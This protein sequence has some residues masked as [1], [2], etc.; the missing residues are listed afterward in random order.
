MLNMQTKTINRILSKKVSDWLLSIDDSYL[1]VQ[2]K[3]KVVV[4]G[5]CI[6]SMLQNQTPNDYDLYI[7][8]PLLCQKLTQYYVNKMKTTKEVLV[9]MRKEG[10]TYEGGVGEEDVSRVSPKGLYVY[11]YIRDSGYVSESGITD[12]NDDI[13]N[14]YEEGEKTPAERSNE[15][16]EKGEEYRP[17]FITSNAVTLSDKFQIITRFSG[18]PDAIHRNFDFVHTQMYWTQEEGV[19][20]DTEAL[21]CVMNKRLVYVGSKFPFCSIVRTRKF[22]SRGWTIDSG[23]YLKMALQMNQLDML[24][25]H[26]LTQQLIGVDT[27]YY[28]WLID[29][30]T[31]SEHLTDEGKIDNNHAMMLITKM[32]D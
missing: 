32:F 21:E 6:T 16:C 25:P 14:E 24:D 8:C 18:E 31:K 3:G 20:T 30:L 10:E 2:L 11:T 26:V 17:V 7:T 4:T 23:Q 15:K 27:T 1:R 5:G 19:V 29:E 9:L 28:A 13:I 22:M 12:N